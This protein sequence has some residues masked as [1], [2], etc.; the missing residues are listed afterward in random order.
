MS[1]GR[2]SERQHNRTND[3]LVKVS[4]RFEFAI[5]QSQQAELMVKQ[6]CLLQAPHRATNFSH[7]HP[8]VQTFSNPSNLLLAYSESK[9]F[10]GV[11][12]RVA[13]RTAYER[14]FPRSKLT[15]TSGTRKSNVRSTRVQYKFR[16]SRRG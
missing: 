10:S 2:L 7:S 11:D 4:V 15:F 6:L 8:F 3:S 1:V 12:V 5:T 16:I 13:R 14:A 9:R